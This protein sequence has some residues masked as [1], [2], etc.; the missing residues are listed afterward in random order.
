MLDFIFIAH[1]MQNSKILFKKHKKTKLIGIE[2]NKQT[3]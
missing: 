3:N 1:V 2:N